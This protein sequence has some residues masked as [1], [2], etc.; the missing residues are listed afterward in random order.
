MAKTLHFN[1]DGPEDYTGDGNADYPLP[2]GTSLT[3]L[4]SRT[5]LAFDGSGGTISAGHTGATAFGEDDFT[6]AMWV[7]WT[8][9][10]ASN[11]PTF[12]DSGAYSNGGIS[13]RRP[14]NIANKIQ[15]S[16]PGWSASH[17][18]DFT[19]SVG[20][21]YHLAVVRSGSTLIA[22]IDGAS[23]GSVAYSHNLSSG[24]LY[25]GMSRHSSSEGLKNTYLDDVRIYDAALDT[26]ELASIMIDYDGYVAPDTTAPVITLLGDD[27]VALVP[28]A[29]YADAGA[30]AVDDTDGAVPVVTTGVS[31]INVAADANWNDVTLLLP[32]DGNL[33]D[34]SNQNNSVT[35][36]G[37]TWQTGSPAVG[38]GNIY[39]DYNGHMVAPIP[40]GLMDGEF[41]IEW[42]AKG[43]NIPVG[44][45]HNGFMEGDLSFMISYSSTGWDA[46]GRMLN[47]NIG[48][49]TS[50]PGH[51]Y[52]MF[53]KSGI[54][55]GDGSGG[56]DTV[57]EH[58]AVVRYF[59]N[60]VDASGGM[61]MKLFINGV[62]NVNDSYASGVTTYGDLTANSTTAPP[63]TMN[64]GTYKHRSDQNWHGAVD[65]FRITKGVARYTANFSVPTEA[66]PTAATGGAIEGTH[67]VTYTATD[68]AN[69][70][71]TATRTVN[72]A[73][74]SVPAGLTKVFK[75][76]GNAFDQDGG[77]EGSLTDPNGTFQYI[78][79]D[80]TTVA[81]FDGS[82]YINIGDRNL[83]GSWTV[84]AWIKRS[85]T[86][87]SNQAWLS[88][89]PLNTNQGNTLHSFSNSVGTLRL[90]FFGDDLDTPTG[91]VQDGVWAHVVLSYDSS[92]D[93]SSIYVDGVKIVDGS[94]GPLLMPNGS[95]DVVIGGWPDFGMIH[96]WEG[97]IGYVA[98]WEGTDLDDQAVADLYAIGRELP[99]NATILVNDAT[100]LE[101]IQGDGEMAVPAGSFT[102]AAT[103]HNGADISGGVEV[104]DANGTLIS[105]PHS[106]PIGLNTLTF[107]VTGVSGVEVS[108]SASIDITDTSDPILTMPDGDSAGSPD[109]TIAQGALATFPIATATDSGYSSNT[110]TWGIYE[111]D[112]LIGQPGDL[113]PADHPG[114]TI[115]AYTVIDPSG[116]WA[117]D[118]LP[119]TVVDSTA[120]IITI[121]GDNPTIVEFG[122]GNYVDA[123]A[124]ALDPVD[125]NVTGN[126]VVSGDIVNA[127]VNGNYYINYSATDAA[128]NTGYATR[129]V[130]VADTTAPV[131][132]LN[133]Q[134]AVSHTLNSGPYVDAGA[135]AIDAVEGDLTGSLITSGSVNTDIARD[136][137]ITYEVSDS[138]G[139]TASSVRTVSVV[140]GISENNTVLAGQRSW[141]RMVANPVVG[142][143]HADNGTGI[144]VDNEHAIVIRAQN[145]IIA[146]IRSER[147]PNMWRDTLIPADTLFSINVSRG[148]LLNFKSYSSEST[149][150]KIKSVNRIS[151]PENTQIE[152]EVDTAEADNR[153]FKWLPKITV[154]SNV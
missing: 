114:N 85:G 60:G 65:G 107:R 112:D 151:S 66:Y 8:D 37:H 147:D 144:N 89:I 140:A 24:E 71:A 126:I 84:A 27:P 70:V 79:D 137:L 149:K 76:D 15:I 48:G 17:E 145:A 35:A 120:P 78:E 73:A 148:D 109:I 39:L 97:K 13:I 56:P 117:F 134:S 52:G 139:N 82:Q 47:V 23:I 59:V 63:A 45:N 77:F 36:T 57:W 101:A 25:I 113:I 133:G 152:N 108:D 21:W 94:A 83:S 50:V 136:Y 90:G 54:G 129:T 58:A 153:T 127:S 142:D 22:Y 146:S 118:T 87:P 130:V 41:T 64:I 16:T 68:A 12:F 1:F 67:T 105:F 9:T 131:I 128:G 138:S 26:S 123:G 132:I 32:L 14:A 116:N 135:V 49:V 34:A 11:Y 44:T 124:T 43:D 110:L 69:N 74:P 99:G 100:A 31:A 51:P 72:V 141:Q 62:E 102:I 81:E 55:A 3:T 122:S 96:S 111:G 92:A 4:G 154:I 7:Y 29:A 28:G 30:T 53:A 20:Q 61:K 18:F 88:S 98:L 106:L 104:F 5:V 121:L 91:Y 33:I 46:S 6:I 143:N 95:Y 40:A 80:G 42:F 119:V 75:F 93:L 103:D 19:P 10:D 125:T 150:V 2:S 86:G 115:Y 38:S